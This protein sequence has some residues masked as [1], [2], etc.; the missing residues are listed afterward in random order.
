MG[1]N[2]ITSALLKAGTPI[3]LALFRAYLEKEESQ[4][5]G[6]FLCNP[7]ARRA[8]EAFDLENYSDEAIAKYM[9]YDVIKEIFGNRVIDAKI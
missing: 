1:K 8:L 4:P 7:A 9:T 5:I 3:Q 6:Y 2:E